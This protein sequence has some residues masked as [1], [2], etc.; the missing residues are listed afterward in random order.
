ML[1]AGSRGPGRVSLQDLQDL[2]DQPETKGP[3]RPRVEIT[4]DFARIARL[5]RRVWQDDPDLPRLADL[6][7]RRLK[8]PN[9]TQSL[10]LSQAAMIRDIVQ[11]GGGFIPAGVG[12]GKTLPSF[13]AGAVL[14]TVRNV[15]VVPGLADGLGKTKDDYRAYAKHWRLP[16][17]TMLTYE[18]IGGEQREPDPNTGELPPGVL[19]TYHPEFIF[20]DEAGAL[21]NTGT[22]TWRA[23]RRTI[24]RFK[25]IVAFADGSFADD[26]GRQYWHMMLASLREKA[27]TPV[28]YHEMQLWC[29]A[30][31]V[32]PR[33]DVD[34]GVLETLSD[35]TPEEKGLSPTTRARTAYQ[36]RLTE[37]PGV[38]ATAG[39]EIPPVRLTL[40]E[41]TVHLSEKLQSALRTMRAKKE[42]PGGEKIKYALDLYRHGGELACGY[43]TVFDPPPPLE[44]SDAR[45]AIHSFVAETLE[46]SRKLDKPSD[47]IRAIDAGTLPGGVDLLADWREIRDTFDPVSKA[48]WIDDSPLRNAAEWLKEHPDHGL[49]WTS[50]V[51]AG[52]RL[53]E[54]SGVPFFASK[55]RPTNRIRYGKK[56]IDKHTSSAIV[57]L[58]ACWK[59][60]NLQ[61]HHCE[62]LYIDIPTKAKRWEQSIGRTHR[63][64]QQRDVSVEAWLACEEHENAIAM[65]IA[66][67][68]Y[69]KETFNTPQKLLYAENSLPDAVMQRVAHVRHQIEDEDNG[70]EDSE[71][72]GF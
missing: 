22:A 4:P 32:Q 48:I 72:S 31:D 63:S 11:Q 5:P 51:P 1:R 14:G 45:Y 61:H 21:Q 59:M 65:A 25:P 9:G 12:T 53:S 34:P 27:P 20:F 42:T 18:K 58:S 64:G 28:H 69:V 13:L 37:T 10:R 66:R 52:E 15:V 16:P 2:L 19:E 44:W 39:E 8:T 41:R 46:H 55:G 38:V 26:T 43:Y 29:N 40:R 7:T 50:H 30:M 68:R 57:S 71:D 6:L 24:T 67:A 3:Y 17:V 23:V 47:V 70:E 36:R 33:E 49:V 60:F 56:R 35:L 54:L 62:N